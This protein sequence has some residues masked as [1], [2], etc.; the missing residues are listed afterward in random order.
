MWEWLT[1]DTQSPTTGG[2]PPKSE[3]RQ[4]SPV[5]LTS[6]SSVRDLLP[7]GDNTEEAWKEN[8]L[9]GFPGI[10]EPECASNVTWVSRVSLGLPQLRRAG[11]T[12]FRNDSWTNA[13]S[14]KVYFSFLQTQ[15]LRWSHICMNYHSNGQ[16][17]GA[18]SSL[19]KHMK[20]KYPFEVAV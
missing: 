6:W 12:A 10:R 15:S 7:P 8:S 2:Y 9:S 5:A 14:E 1:E 20:N 13:E 3:C 16:H 11:N 18:F 4:K 17:L 19:L